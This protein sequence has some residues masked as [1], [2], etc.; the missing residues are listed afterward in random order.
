MLRT[1]WAALVLVAVATAPAVAEDN[2]KFPNREPELRGTTHVV[3]IEPPEAYTGT[4][5]A[6]I[7]PYIYLNRCTGGCSVSASAMNDARTNSSS[8]PKMGAGCPGYPTC[9]VA[10]FQNAAGETGAAADQEWNEVVQCLKEVYS[11]FAVTVTDQKPSNGASYTMALIAGTPANIGLGDGILGIAPL[12]G[13]CSAQDNVISFSFANHHG[14]TDR[15]N[16]LCWTAAQETAHALGLDHE[17]MFS[18]GTSACNDPMTYRFDCGGQKFFRNK[19]ASCGEDSVR[20][21]Q[22]GGSQNSHV[23]IKGVF[24]EGTSLIPPPTV[25]LNSPV[26]GGIATANQIV[27][28]QSG[29]KRGVAKLELYLN[30]YKWAEVAGAA[31][32]SQGQRNPSDYILRFPADVPDG[33]IDI[34]VKASDDLGLTTSSATVTVTKGAPCSSA[35]SCAKGQKCEAGKCFWD[36]PTG[37][38]GDACDYNQF[39]DTGICLETSDGGLCSQDCIVGVKDGCPTDFECLAVGNAGRCVAAG[40]DTGCCSVGS[41]DGNS[42]WLHFGL[43]AAV[44]G[45]VVRRRRR[46]R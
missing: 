18:D 24:G 44:I 4:T 41:K 42:P 19:P 30:D 3:Q 9:V 40:E 2:T 5:A 28:A 25:V 35:A 34:V 45:F 36:A 15:V 31:F 46:R 32:G 43:S 29:S 22:C 14:N 21:C 23:K 7:S 6:T 16:N 17:Y 8:I 1:C 26:N 20:P 27:G 39:C 12:A 37:V 11:P 13:D 38:L 33:V 10:E